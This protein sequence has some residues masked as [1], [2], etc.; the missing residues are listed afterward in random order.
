MLL[1]RHVQMLPNV[2]VLVL[3][4]VQAWYVHFAG[5]GTVVGVHCAGTGA[6]RGA[7]ASPV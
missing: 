2:K 4:I 6:G 7:G 5:T 3:L 1:N